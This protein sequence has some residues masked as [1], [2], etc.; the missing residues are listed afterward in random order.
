MLFGERFNVSCEGHTE[1]TD[2]VLAECRDCSSQE[3]HYVSAT[4]PNQLMLFGETITV[5]CEYHT[6]HTNTHCV[7]NVEIVHHR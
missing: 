6:E 3:T 4:K 5:Y 7:Q 1:H 2:K